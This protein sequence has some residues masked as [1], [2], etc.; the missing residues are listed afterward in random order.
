M[1]LGLLFGVSLLKAYN[2]ARKEIANLAP[3]RK[4]NQCLPLEPEQFIYLFFIFI[5]YVLFFL[6]FFI[7][8][9]LNLF[10]YLSV[11]SSSFLT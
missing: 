10:I 11:Y 6:L 4:E 5:F 1:L 7:F 9:F 8:F 2:P 3:N